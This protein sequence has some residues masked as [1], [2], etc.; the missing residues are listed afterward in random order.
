MRFV[1]RLWLKMVA[2]KQ[3]QR[4]TVDQTDEA[5]RRSPSALWGHENWSHKRC[6]NRLSRGRGGGGGA[7]ISVSETFIYGFP[8]IIGTKY[9]Y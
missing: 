6:M 3:L 7:F 5:V 2:L 9:S 4:Q 1:D 8:Y